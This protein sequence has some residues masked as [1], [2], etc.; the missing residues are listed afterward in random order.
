M[1]RGGQEG[2]G[3]FRDFRA[4]IKK[5]QARAEENALKRI[6][7]ASRKQW[8]AAAWWLERKYPERWGK[9][10]RVE[11]P[12][13]SDRSAAYISSLSATGAQMPSREELIAEAKR[14][15]AEYEAAEVH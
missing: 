8:Q 9:R 2:C 12:V 11:R 10:E 5:A 15:I 3:V 1:V 7:T 6:Q 13:E 14:L 4:A